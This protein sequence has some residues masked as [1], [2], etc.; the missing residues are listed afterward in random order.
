MEGERYVN[1]RKVA[2][3]TDR[4]LP[5]LRN[6]RSKGVG[7]PYCKVGKSVRYRLSDVIGFMEKH[8]IQTEEGR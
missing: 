4:G 8:K 7:I 3:L 1:E 6:D 2:E 5:T